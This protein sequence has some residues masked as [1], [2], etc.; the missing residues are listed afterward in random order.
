[1][2]LKSGLLTRMDDHLRTPQPVKVRNIP[3]MNEN[4]QLIPST[5]LVPLLPARR[6][7]LRLLKPFLSFSPLGNVHEEN[8]E[9]T[10]VKAPRAGM[11]ILAPTKLKGVAAGTIATQQKVA[12]KVAP[13]ALLEGVAAEALTIAAKNSCAAALLCVF[14]KQS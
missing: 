3:N 11:V 9:V 1:M 13:C 10:N 6:S 5:W 8:T 12:S 4:F 7:R 2:T 14:T